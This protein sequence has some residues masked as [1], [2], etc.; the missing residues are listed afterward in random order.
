M[1]KGNPFLKGLTNA[2]II[3]LRKHSPYIDKVYDPKTNIVNYEIIIER[4][5]NVDKAI[6]SEEEIFLNNIKRNLIREYWRQGLTLELTINGKYADRDT[7]EGG[8]SPSKKD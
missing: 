4:L 2:E 6:I 7:G 8:W 1:A 5:K 3:R